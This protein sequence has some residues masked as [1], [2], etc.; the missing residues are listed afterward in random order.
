MTCAIVDL[1][2]YTLFPHTRD[3]FIELFD[4]QF[5]E[6]QEAEGIRVIGQFRD[7]G[8]PNRFVW[9]RG[10]ADMP[11]RRRGLEA[12]YLHGAAWKEHA[13]AARA[14]MIDTD[15]VLMLRPVDA[16]GAFEL[17]PPAQRPALAS[18][19]PTSLVIVTIHHVAREQA[20]A[21]TRFYR[22]QALPEL[23]AA[24]GRLRALLETDP[25]PNNFPRLPVREGENVLVSVMAF[26]DPAHHDR[27]METLGR[28]SRWCDEVYPALTRQLQMPPQQ[29]RLAPTSRS[30][31]R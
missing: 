14:A 26:D 30:Q 27:H 25:S 11:S 29:L 28:S 6:T 18:P 9:M 17:P 15:D 2:Q 3:R 10:Y 22:E 8:D 7:L 12:F 20:A 23:L 21:F 16:A 1:R 4:A 13:A 5:V 24:G 19:L 31:L